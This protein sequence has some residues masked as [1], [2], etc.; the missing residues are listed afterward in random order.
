MSKPP[1]AESGPYWS[2]M[3]PPPRKFTEGPLGDQHGPPEDQYGTTETTAQPPN[4]LQSD[5]QS[6]SESN[7]MEETRGREKPEVVGGGSESKE[8]DLEASGS[9]PE[10]KQLMPPPPGLAPRVFATPPMP[11]PSFIPSRASLPP[12]A[13]ECLL[14]ITRCMYVGGYKV[15]FTIRSPNI[16]SALIPRHLC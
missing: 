2:Q 5:H 11:P 13:S 6:P 9:S 4:S 3:V 7:T 15:K 14:S 16:Y 10:E 1:T 8:G 12:P